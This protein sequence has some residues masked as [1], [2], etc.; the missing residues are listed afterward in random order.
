MSSSDSRFNKELA[1]FL[2]HRQRTSSGEFDK[3]KITAYVTL[4][5]WGLL[6]YGYRL[7]MARIS[8]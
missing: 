8:H 2:G 3:G 1:L 7:Y 6:I 4:I 5:G